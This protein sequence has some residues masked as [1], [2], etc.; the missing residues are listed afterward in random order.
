MDLLIPAQVRENL[1]NLLS[2]EG[3][4][5]SALKGY[6]DKSVWFINNL[7]REKDRQGHSL[8]EFTGMSSTI[9]QYYL[10]SKGVQ[11]VKSRL[12]E[13]AIITDNNKYSTR[14]KFSKSY[15]LNPAVFDD[16]ILEHKISTVS[17][18]NKHKIARKEI[19]EPFLEAVY[20][21]IAAYGISSEVYEF[22]SSQYKEKELKP[23]QYMSYYLRA[24]EIEFKDLYVIRDETGR[25]YT[26]F[27]NLPKLM[28]SYIYNGSSPLTICEVDISACMAFILGAVMERNAIEA[29]EVALFIKLSQEPNFYINLAS[30][31]SVESPD[32]KKEFLVMLNEK[33]ESNVKRPTYRSFKKSFPAVAAFIEEVNKKDNSTL[34]RMCAS[35]ESTVM[36]NGVYKK[37]IAY[38][39]PAFSIHDGILTTPEHIDL[40]TQLIQKS[41]R[42]EVGRV[43]VI[44]VK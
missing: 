42:E 18:L 41:F 29:P 19:K 34:Y 39:I 23:M 16:N 27:T 17:L 28:R 5:S 2:K 30:L 25:V 12:L 33:Y 26:N 44:K 36:I 32:F 9:L 21:H 14:E 20:H 31:L 6:V 24:K 4:K 22:L 38:R 40:V 13:L 35:L 15:G 1:T 7:I 8:G 43:P 10:G 11:E 3:F 37:L